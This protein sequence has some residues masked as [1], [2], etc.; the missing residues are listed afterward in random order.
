ME[1][2]R[3]RV[4]RE[5]RVAV[6]ARSRRV[7]APTS[8]STGTSGGN[9]G[10]SL[11]RTARPCHMRGGPQA[12]RPGAG[13]GREGRRPDPGSEGSPHAG[14]DRGRTLR[15]VPGGRSYGS[16]KASTL[17]TD[18]GRIKRHIAPRPGKRL[19]K[20]LIHADLERFQ[21]DVTN[22]KTA[23]DEKTGFRGSAIV[24]GGKRA[25]ARTMGLPDPDGDVLPAGA[26]LPALRHVAHPVDQAALAPGCTESIKVNF[27]R[28]R[29]L[30]TADCQVVSTVQQVADRIEAG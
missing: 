1:R 21:R 15:A 27:H 6:E 25:A 2:H 30:V 7:F 13:R 4:Y 18:R 24:P 14:N 29:A 5:L 11:P 22:G 8:S 12:R 10:A 20:D 23:A 19:V 9:R 28:P 3:I 17:D 16:K 26:A